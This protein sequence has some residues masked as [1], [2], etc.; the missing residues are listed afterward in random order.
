MKDWI[1]RQYE[2]AKPFL[3]GG[4]LIATHAAFMYGGSDIAT[5]NADRERETAV[6][7]A[8]ATFEP[9]PLNCKDNEII[10]AVRKLAVNGTHATGF[11]LWLEMDNMGV[12][13]GH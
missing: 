3:I 4:V 6:R 8:I 13:N 7:E 1:K 5:R 11:R 2:D 10:E 12:S 9:S